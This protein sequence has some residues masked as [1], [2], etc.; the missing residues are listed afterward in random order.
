V[1]L[2]ITPE[3]AREWLETAEDN[4]RRIQPKRVQAIASAIVAGGWKYNGESIKFNSDKRLVDGQHRLTAVVQSGIP[5]VSEVVEGIDEI[6]EIDTGKPRTAA[7]VLHRHGYINDRQLAATVSLLIQ[8]KSGKMFT[9]TVFPKSSYLTLL[10]ECPSITKSVSHGC[11]TKRRAGLRH[12]IY[13]F[14]HYCF[15]RADSSDRDAY[16]EQLDKGEGLESG[17][18]VFTL[19]EFLRTQVMKPSHLRVSQE[20]MCAATIKAWNCY[21]SNRELRIIRYSKFKANERF[22]SISGFEFYTPEQRSK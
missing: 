8:F 13:S 21:R 18:P 14:C 4:Y 1:K 7:D 6:D 10:Q 22:P 17:H 2:R 20:F 11:V 9:S 16:F 3:M 5:I 19:R 15:G 12:T